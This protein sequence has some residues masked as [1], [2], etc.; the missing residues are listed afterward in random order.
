MTSEVEHTAYILHKRPFRETSVLVDLFCRDRGRIRAVARG[1]RSKRGN[2]QLSL[3]PFAPTIISW[4]GKTDLKTLIRAEMAGPANPA[5]S[6]QHLYL[7]LYVNE[8][9]MRLLAE[10]DAHEYL[11]QCYEQLLRQLSG[12]SLSAG[13][14]LEPLLREF[15]LSLL[16]EIGYGLALTTNAVNG[17]PIRADVWYRLIQNEGLAKVSEFSTAK[18][19]EL[20][21]GAHLLSIAERNYAEIEVRRCAKRLLR[22]ALA[23]HLGSK[24]LQ[25]REFFR[26]NVSVGARL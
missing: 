26:D 10:G 4:R 1:A 5:L 24:P 2:K 16:E 18:Q 22:Q 13:E 11:Y 21:L 17:D 8:L 14:E 23:H 12:G 6:G 9:L 20:F 3:E 25:S 15:E 19:G 7:G